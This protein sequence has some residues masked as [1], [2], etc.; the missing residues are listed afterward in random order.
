[1]M[2]IFA[3]YNYTFMMRRHDIVPKSCHQLQK[4]TR[5]KKPE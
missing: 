2:L 1:M 5:D 3:T 4:R